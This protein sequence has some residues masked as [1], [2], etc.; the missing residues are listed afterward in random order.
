M[1]HIAELWQELFGK[2]ISRFEH[3]ILEGVAKR[4]GEDDTTLILCAII[5]HFLVLILFR[6]PESPFVVAKTTAK[7]LKGELIKLRDYLKMDQDHSYLLGI[8]LRDLRQTVE[9]TENALNRAR[10]DARE[11]EE[12]PA[13][14]YQKM[15]SVCFVSSSA[16]LLAS[17]I[18]LKLI[19]AL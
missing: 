17:F 16:G 19:A 5:I 14:A 11:R 1:S 4:V 7:E 2:E 13:R 9:L 10:K 15:A 3:E 18:F 6:D 8:E 12:F